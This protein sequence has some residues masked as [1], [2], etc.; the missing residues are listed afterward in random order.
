MKL[1]RTRLGAAV[2]AAIQTHLDLLEGLAKGGEDD[3]QLEGRIAHFG[4]SN[5]AAKP[6]TEA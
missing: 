1:L 4:S 5:R 6:E 3:P 2:R